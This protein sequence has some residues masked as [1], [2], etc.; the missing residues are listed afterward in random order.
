MNA[1]TK[2]SDFLPAHE[3]EAQALAR[4]FMQ[5]NVAVADTGPIT[6]VCRQK[7]IAKLTEIMD[8]TTDRKG[9]L[10]SAAYTAKSKNR[11]FR[12]LGH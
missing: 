1:P 7:I 2:T 12:T 6:H 10:H 4:V 11:L 5:M 8:I 9:E 3:L